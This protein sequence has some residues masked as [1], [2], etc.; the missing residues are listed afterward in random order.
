MLYVI[1]SVLKLQK[2]RVHGI[3]LLGN[4]FTFTFNHGNLHT[5]TLEKILNGI[6]MC[7]NG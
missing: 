5:P 6:Q 7:F 2:Q 3:M 4:I 1:N